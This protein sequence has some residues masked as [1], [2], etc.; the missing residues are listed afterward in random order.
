MFRKSS[1]TIRPLEYNDL[2]IL[3]DWQKYPSWPNGIDS[4]AEKDPTSLL[5]DHTANPKNIILIAESN[6][7]EP[8]GMVHLSTYAS[9]LKHAQYSIIIPEPCNRTFGRSRDLSLL[10]IATAF[11]VYDFERI[12]AIIDKHNQKLIKMSLKVG[13]EFESHPNNFCDQ[14]ILST[15]PEKWMS[16]WG[17]EL[18]NKGKG[19]PWFNQNAKWADIR[20][21]TTSLPKHKGFDSKKPCLERIKITRAP[22]DEEEVT[23]LDGLPPQKVL[24]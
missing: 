10:S 3:K 20:K 13:F 4:I 24:G 8:I 18:M 22:S 21:A 6:F 7:C 5:L 15:T 23:C 1:V 12:F 17:V 11:Y 19:V 14:A 16:I 9:P 2:R